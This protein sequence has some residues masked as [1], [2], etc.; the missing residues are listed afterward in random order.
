MGGGVQQMLSVPLTPFLGT[1]QSLHPESILLLVHQRVISGCRSMRVPCR[2]CW[3]VDHPCRGR[4]EL[5]KMLAPHCWGRTT[6][7]HV[8]HS[9]LEVPSGIVPWRPTAVTF[10]FTNIAL[11]FF[12]SLP[13]FSVRLLVLLGVTSL[14][15]CS[16]VFVSVILVGEPNLRLQ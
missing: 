3:E 8:L 14:I 5:V 16:Q 7:W 12:S 1:H 9:L 11:A 4:Q 10:S 15:T 13:S 2:T 6:L